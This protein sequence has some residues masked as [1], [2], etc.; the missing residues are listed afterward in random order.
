MS[1]VSLHNHSDYSNIRGLDSINTLEGL[2]SRAL[3]LN[4]LGLAITDH[5]VLSGHVKATQIHEKLDPEKKMKLLLGNEIYI[6]REGLIKENYEKGEKLFHFLLLALNKEGHKQLRE[7]S[8]RAWERS[9]FLNVPR[10]PTY[11][12]DLQEIIGKS[13]GNVVAT[14]ACLAGFPGTYY[15][16]FKDGAAKMIDNKL[17]ELEKIFGKGNLFLEIQPSLLKEHKDFNNFMIKNF[18]GKYPFVFTTDSHYLESNDALYHEQFLQSANRSRDVRSFYSNNYLMT[19]DDIRT[20]FY[21]IDE[22]KINE[23][24]ENTIS[25]G[26]R[27]EFYSLENEQIVPTVSTDYSKDG[28]ESLRKYLKTLTDKKYEYIENYLNTD[29]IYDVDFIQKIFIGFQE[30][31]KKDREVDIYLSR[32]NEELSE[33]WETSI[34]IHQPLSKYFTTMAKMI[35]I[36][37][38]EGDSLVGVSR[39]SAAGFLINYYLRITQIDPLNQPLVMPHWRFIHK[40]R[41]GLPD[42]DID[43]EGDKRTKVFHKVQEYF[44]NIGGDFINVSTFGTE[45]AKAA[46]RT[47]GRALDIEDD[48]IS[49][50]VSMI[51]NE[52][53]FDWNLSECMYGEGD[54]KALPAFKTEMAKHKNLWALAYKIEGLITSISVHASGVIAVNEALTEHNSIMRTSRGIRVTAFNLEDTEYAGGIKYDFLTINALD[55][56]RTTMNLLLEDGILDWHGTLRDTYNHYLLPVNLDYEDQEMWQMVADG[57]IVDLFQFDTQVG[58]QAVRLI[59]PKNI[60]EL[61]VANSVMRL[62]PEGEGELPLNTY[63]GYKHDIRGWYQEMK[64]AGLSEAE[65]KILEEHLLP[66]SGVADSQESAM[67]LVMDDRIAGFTVTEANSLRRAIG[68]KEFET[69]RQTEIMFYQKGTA[70]GTSRKMLEYVWNVQIYRQA[71]YS[72]SVLHTMGYSTIALQEM[73]LAYKFPVIYWNTACLSVNAGAINEEDY[74][75]LIED[76][77]VVIEED[78][79]ED[80]KS[81]KVQYGKIAGAIEKFRKEL[82]LKIALPDIN[83]AR[84]GF[85]PD[86][87]R[88]EVLFGLKGITRI[89]D[90]LIQTIIENRPYE[91]LWDFIQKLNGEGKTIISKDRVVILIKAGA[92]DNL[93][94]KTREELLTDFILSVADQKK[95]LTLQNAK[96]L[97]DYNLIP[98][99]YDFQKRIYNY[100]RYIRKSR[101]GN[102][103]Y[104]L[105]DI[106]QEF[107]Y[108]NSY[109]IDKITIIPQGGQNLHI[110]S[111]SYWD[112]IYETEMNYIRKYITDNHDEL[113]NALNTIL[114]NEEYEKYAA[115]NRLK[116]ELQSLGFYHE[117]HELEGIDKTFPESVKISKLDDIVDM[118]TI[119]SFLIKGKRIPKYN[120]YHI[121]GT[122]LDKDK[123]KH[124]IVFSTPNGV[125]NVK[126]YRAQF[127]VLDKVNFIINE[128]GEKEVI[129]DSFFKKG[130]FLMISG[131]KEGDIFKPKTY[132]EHGIDPV[133]M[134]EIEDGKFKVAHEKK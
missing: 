70:L 94:E 33:I 90:K 119:G 105:D 12:S 26:E 65:I 125:I 121:I 19:L 80:K 35:D 59:K 63:A 57:Q 42:I 110:L 62:M 30:R 130:T 115:G 85:V 131:I 92:F 97:I 54:R 93:T 128:D 112:S 11:E 73:N 77:I 67:M 31:F 83:R 74:H 44:R 82:G 25:I 10:T 91:S 16:I 28:I 46:L 86:A 75:A 79:E 118:E 23:M 81:S 21:Y 88:N 29:N 49:Y 38:T 114:F 98:D 113:L 123:Q 53:G 71:G 68:K 17:K 127:S 60:A 95:K 5:D 27:A 84:F 22:S 3:Q 120:I 41:P 87:Y 117:A 132:K 18:W 34:Q 20:S 129:Q 56:I 103:N 133:L 9:F 101:D 61:S 37:W 43:T 100:T 58:T 134:F 111:S 69:M 107:F 2:I 24:I 89:G 52:R 4:F 64:R 99:D 48:I 39:G 47:A 45:K 104:I 55:K 122:V 76:E 32:I 124:L 6:S 96:M 66:L 106:A 102:R 7:I 14:T 78:D 72:F 13:Q 8:S 1:Y 51:P 108:E 40:D 109:N 116:W 36:I 15:G 126:M 50:L